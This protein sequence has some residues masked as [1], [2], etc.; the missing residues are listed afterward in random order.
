MIFLV[1]LNKVFLC[2][3]GVVIIDDQPE[4][5]IDD[6]NFLFE[7]NEGFQEVTSKRTQKSKQ[8]AQQEAEQQKQ[9][10]TK[11]KD[12]SLTRVS[13]TNVAKVRWKG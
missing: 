13:K 8:K 4:V 6:P 3:S 5:S 11:K 9:V 7:N 1:K 2:Y 10:E 12:S